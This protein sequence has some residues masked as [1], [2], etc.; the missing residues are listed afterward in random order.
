[1]QLACACREE[2]N[3]K[4]VR[5]WTA[6]LNVCCCLQAQLVQDMQKL[7]TDHFDWATSIVLARYPGAVQVCIS[8]GFVLDAK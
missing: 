8:H 3:F 4:W 7:N 6:D 5:S 2:W 1:M